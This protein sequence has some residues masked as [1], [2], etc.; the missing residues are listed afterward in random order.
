M[1]T[2][3]DTQAVQI[4]LCF[5][6]GLAS[7]IIYD[8]FRALRRESTWRVLPAL[9]DTVFC[10]AVCFA[11]FIIG[12]SAG[13]GSLSIT[14]LAFALV[15]FA[16]YMALFS[17]AVLGLFR[18]VLL[19]IK[20]ILYPLKK[21]FSAVSQMTKT[22]LS[23]AVYWLKKQLALRKKNGGATLEKTKDT[24]D[25]GHRNYGDADLWRGQPFHNDASTAQGRKN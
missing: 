12:M 6:M 5:L 16:C 19:R 11:L 15:G 17:N 9:L 18:R 20:K 10:A 2:S 23:K 8:A 3:V 21:Y 25:N 7:G 13:E 14:M 24:D 22:A 1:K 4:S